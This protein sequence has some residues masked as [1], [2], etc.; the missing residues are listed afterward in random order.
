MAG[1]KEA[2]VPRKKKAPAEKQEKEAT[3]QAAPDLI[4][5]PPQNG[6]AKAEESPAFLAAVKARAAEVAREC[7]LKE[8]FLLTGPDRVDY[9]ERGHGYIVV[10]KEETGRQRMGSARFDAEGQH[11]YW[12]LDGIVTG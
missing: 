10:V 6:Q 11:R 5:P 4:P 9:P 12:S 3:V 2:A 1:S 8:P 7:G